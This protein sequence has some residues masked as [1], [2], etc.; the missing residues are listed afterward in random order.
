MSSLAN[1][2]ANGGKVAW[3]WTKSK[4]KSAIKAISTYLTIAKASQKISSKVKKNSKQRYWK[5]DIINKS[6]YTYVVLG[7]AISYSQAKARVSAGKSVFTVTKAEARNLARNFGGVV[8]PEIGRK[9]LGQYWHYHVNNRKN[10]AH[11][12]YIF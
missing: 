7:S 5:A 10:K 2:I 4:L 11:I 3:N 8:G 12:F 1:S 6:G 9:S